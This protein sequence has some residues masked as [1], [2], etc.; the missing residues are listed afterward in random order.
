M[1][2]SVSRGFLKDLKNLDPRLSVFWNGNHQVIRFQRPNGEAVNI[3]RVKAEDGGYRE[4]GQRDLLAVAG[5][6]LAKEDMKTRLLKLSYAS[7]KMREKAR[8]DARDNIRYMTKDSKT[9]LANAAIQLTNQGK[10][11][12]AHR[13]IDPD[14]HRKGR[15]WAEIKG[16]NARA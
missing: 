13:R 8:A 2:P 6:D 10:G 7:E 16:E 5:G 4:P 3:Y 15:T 11:N 12:S 14:A 9:Q 1:G